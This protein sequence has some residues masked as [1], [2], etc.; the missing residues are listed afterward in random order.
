MRMLAVTTFFLFAAATCGEIKE[1]N[2]VRVENPV[3]VKTDSGLEYTITAKGEGPQAKVGDQV[4]VHYT[5]R[6]SNGEKFDSSLDNGEP[7]KFTIGKSRVIQGWHE[8]FALLHAGDKATL[9]IPPHLAYGS[10]DRNG[11]PANSTLFFE[12]ELLGIAGAK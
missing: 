7:Y 1:Y 4:I 9:K 6:F 12:V 3:T 8:A 11:I 5:G 10:T 2:S